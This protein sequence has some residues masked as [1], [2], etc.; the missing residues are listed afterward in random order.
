[1]LDTR[2]LTTHQESPFIFLCYHSSM[3]NPIEKGPERI[4]T[5]E[6]VM[7]VIARYAENTTFVRE[8]SDEQGLYLLEVKIEGKKSGE[9]IQ[10]EYMRKGRFPNHNE[11]SE[12]AVC[13]VYYKD[14][15]PMGGDKI[16]VYNPETGEWEEVK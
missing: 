7:E 12:T 6:E 9:I 5:K 13:V 16:A 14:E 8:L 4:L 2:C 15:V 10:Y 3:E 1:M 11:A